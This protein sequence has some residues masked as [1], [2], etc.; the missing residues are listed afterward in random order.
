MWAAAAKAVPLPVVITHVK[1]VSYSR[2]ALRTRSGEGA[3]PDVAYAEPLA[4]LLNLPEYPRICRRCSPY[5][6]RVTPGF[7]DHRARIFRSANVTVANHR[8]FYR[9][10][11][12]GNP[13]PARVSAISL[14]ASPR[15]QQIGRASC[16]ERV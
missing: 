13:L 3:R 2:Q 11:H 16:R 5:H 14:L 4:I 1:A 8:N 15:M 9:L 6:D 10:L 7:C 12:R